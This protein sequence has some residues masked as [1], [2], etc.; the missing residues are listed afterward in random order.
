MRRTLFAVPVLAMLALPVSA[1]TLRMSVRIVN[2]QG[3]ASQYGYVVPGYATSNCNVYSYGNTLSSGC[4]SS[5][6]PAMVARFQVQ[7]ATLSLLLP[8]TRIVVVNCNAKTNWT[9]W[10]QGIYRS[11]RVPA[12]DTVEAEFKGDKAK[13]IWSVSLDGKK[14]KSETYKII[15]VLSQ[16]ARTRR[17]L[18]KVEARAGT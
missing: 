9:D 13:L 18:A 11:C 1:K 14:K 4:S 17:I 6:M 7:G 3:S 16:N 15:G 5:R 10:H 8:D 12:A 2:R